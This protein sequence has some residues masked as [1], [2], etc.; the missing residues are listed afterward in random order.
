MDKFSE[1]IEDLCRKHTAVRHSECECHFSNL[2][3]DFDNKLKRVMH[4]PCV[5]IDTE[6]FRIDGSS[7]NFLL[8]NAINVYFLDHVSD[9]GSLSLKMEAFYKTRR[10]M[11]DFMRQFMRDKKAGIAP[12]DRFTPIGNEGTRIEFTDNALYGWVL[13]I[14]VPE[15]IYD[16]DCSYDPWDGVFDET[17]TDV[18]Y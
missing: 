13:A 17:F 10:I 7:G 16:L 4:Y 18:F 12:M 1:Y 8:E 2:L 9:H 6:G 15:V 11:M 5:G 3:S 14:N